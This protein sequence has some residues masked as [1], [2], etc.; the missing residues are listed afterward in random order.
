MIK[1]QKPKKNWTLDDR[2]ILDW[3]VVHF[4]LNKNYKNIEKEFVKIIFILRR[5][6]IGILLLL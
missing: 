2:T 6:T 1:S 3:V 4:A 5:K